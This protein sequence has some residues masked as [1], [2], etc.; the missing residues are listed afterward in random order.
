M[1]SCFENL[2]FCL[3][4]S[5]NYQMSEVD[6]DFLVSRFRHFSELECRGSS[7]LYEHIAAEIAHDQ[8]LLEL[9]SHAQPRQ[10]VPNMLFAAVHYLLLAGADHELRWFYPNLVGETAGKEPAFSPFKEFCILYRSEIIQLLQ[11]RR[12]QTNEVRRC[13]YLYP[14]FCEIHRQ[15]EKPLALFEIGTAS[16]LQLLWDHYSYTYGDERMA[17]G[18]KGSTVQI[19]S[20]IRG[21]KKPFLSHKPPPVAWRAGADISIVDLATDDDFLWLRA[22]VWPEHKDRIDLMTRAV[23]VFKANSPRLIEGDGVEIV[24]EISHEVPG[25]AVLCVYHTHVANQFHPREK[26]DELLQIVDGV[27]QR[28]EICHIYNNMMDGFLHLDMLGV[29][30]PS[31]QIIAKTDGHA[32]WFEWLPYIEDNN[33]NAA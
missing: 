9:A 11:T 23:E 14:V 16:G 24:D 12:G 10:P 5:E 27:A 26:K 3:D 2:I 22:L 32:R 15:L 25:D 28:R 13:A 21:A 17:F 33:A 1:K 31:R 18:A 30:R 4:N 8:D 19:D 6:F 20:E 7:K 29:S